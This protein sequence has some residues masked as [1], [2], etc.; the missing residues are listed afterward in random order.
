MPP[1][2][3]DENERE[4]PNRYRCHECNSKYHLRNNCTV[5]KKKLSEKERGGD[6]SASGSS[7]P[8]SGEQR[9]SDWKFI[10]PAD[11]N[12]T[13][14]VNSL[15]YFYCKHCM[16]KNTNRR[17]FFNR[18]HNLTATTTTSGHKFSRAD[19]GT[20]STS[21]ETT[22]LS[23]SGASTISSLSST[24]YPAGNISAVTLKEN[25]TSLKPV[26]EDHVDKDPEAWNL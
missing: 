13:V 20:T 9:N 11:D 10:A 22:S 17:G 12:V 16:C 14:T 8:K 7:G 21:T 3:S 23:S 2:W 25:K 4:N 26:N 1:D 19:D 18:T 24:A 5:K 6:G 15:E